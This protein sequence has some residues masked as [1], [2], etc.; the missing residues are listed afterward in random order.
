MAYG[1]RQKD[2]GCDGNNNCDSQ[3]IQKCMNTHENHIFQS[4]VISRLS[5]GRHM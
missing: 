3:V 2:V 1:R 4:G 5:T